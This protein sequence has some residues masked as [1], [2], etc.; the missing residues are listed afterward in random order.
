MPEIG[1]PDML[2][3]TPLMSSV[4]EDGTEDETELNTPAAAHSPRYRML[5]SVLIVLVAIYAAALF[6][7][8][9]LSDTLPLFTPREIESKLRMALPSPNLDKGRDIM[10]EKN[11]KCT[12]YC[13]TLRTPHS[14]LIVPAPLMIFPHYMTR[15]NAAEPD[16]IYHSGASV[17]LSPTVSSHYP[18]CR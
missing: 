4:P 17:V 9:V 6:H 14:S 10:D 1:S 11:Y 13:K 12:R 7:L 16:T 8:S 15:V 5:L 18:P 3:Y 2:E